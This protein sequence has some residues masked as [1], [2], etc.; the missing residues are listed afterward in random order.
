MPSSIAPCTRTAPGSTPGPASGGS[1][2]GWRTRSERLFGDGSDL[3]AYLPTRRDSRLDVCV[4]RASPNGG[5]HREKVPATSCWVAVAPAMM[6]AAVIVPVTLPGYVVLRAHP[7]L[8][9]PRGGLLSYPP[10]PQHK[11]RHK[12]GR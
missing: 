9:I 8:S 2:W 6:L 4:S 7:D 11:L 12:A 1:P 3:A 10:L 5:D